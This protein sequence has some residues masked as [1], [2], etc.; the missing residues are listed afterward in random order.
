M[1]GA[2][3]IGHMCGRV[4]FSLSPSG[5]QPDRSPRAKTLSIG[6]LFQFPCGGRC[7]PSLTCSSLRTPNILENPSLDKDFRGDGFKHS[8][9]LDCSCQ[10]KSFPN[11][12]RRSMV[13]LAFGARGWRRRHSFHRR[14]FSTLASSERRS[15]EG[16]NKTASCV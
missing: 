1:Q 3:Q 13:A 16:N 14:T 10:T 12:R 15:K 4:L 9:V 6:C 5:I 7:M 2:A 11:T 8:S